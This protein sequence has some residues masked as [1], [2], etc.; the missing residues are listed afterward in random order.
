MPYE[1]LKINNNIVTSQLNSFL[2]FVKC[3][4]LCP[5]S[6]KRPVLPLKY[7]GRTI[8]PHGKWI[9]TYF[10]EEIKAVIPLGYI[11]KP[12][13]GYEFSKKDLFSDY[14]NHFYQEKKVSKGSQRFIAKMHLNQLYGYF[15]RS[16]ELINT[17]NVHKNDLQYYM[18]KNIIDNIIQINDDIFVLLIKNYVNNNILV[19]LG[20]HLIEE[21]EGKEIYRS[22]V[23]ANVAIASAV[24]AYSRIH[25]I[26]YKLLPGTCY[27]DTE[28][29]VVIYLKLIRSFQG[30]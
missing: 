15:G 2:G 14:V 10:S 1:I 7:N 20:I 9:G 23:K 5:T 29:K 24:T 26:P 13:V 28:N 22:K 25:M 12:L 6:I 27:T 11:I 4:V 21:F 17:I 8:Y 30:V 19:K 3:E 16:L 18:I